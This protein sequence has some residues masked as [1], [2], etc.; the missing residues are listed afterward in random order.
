M[1]TQAVELLKDLAD[2]FDVTTSGVDDGRFVDLASKYAGHDTPSAN[3]LQHSVLATVRKF[4]TDVDPKVAP[5]W[6]EAPHWAG[7]LGQDYNGRWYWFERE[8]AQ[9]ASGYWSVAGGQYRMAKE[10]RATNTKWHLS[11][12]RRPVCQA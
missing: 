3:E 2:A 11:L 7:W 10:A 5:N 9:V 12:Q 8:P 4:L 1:S 6:S